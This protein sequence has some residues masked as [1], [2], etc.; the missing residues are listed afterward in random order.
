[1]HVW[2]RYA[3]PLT[4]SRRFQRSHCNAQEAPVFLAELLEPFGLSAAAKE[5]QAYLCGGFGNETRIDYGT[6]HEMNFVVFLFCLCKLQVIPIVQLRAMMTSVFREYIRTMRRLQELYVLE[7]A[8]SHGVWGLDD[9]HCLL[10]LFGAAQLRGIEES[11]P[12][13]VNDAA[14][15]A[16]KADTF[17]YFEGIQ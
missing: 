15:L 1:M 2:F 16:E 9:Y 7:P 5:L 3:A 4:H 10:F 6:G 13:D 8:G 17:L 11:K 14:L 12:A